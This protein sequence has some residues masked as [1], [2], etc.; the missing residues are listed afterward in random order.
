MQSLPVLPKSV[1]NVILLGGG[2]DTA[3]ML[4]TLAR[5]R[6]FPDAFVGLFV[7]YMQTA[8]HG[9]KHA[10]LAVVK[11]FGLNHCIGSVRVPM[12]DQVSAMVHGMNSGPDRFPLAHD[13]LPAEKGLNYYPARNLI[14]ASMAYSL[15]DVVGAEN[16]WTA[17]TG[18]TD[19]T[20]ADELYPDTGRRFVGAIQTAGNIATRR[21]IAVQAPLLGVSKREVVSMGQRLE[22]P[23][24]DT[25]SC[26]RGS[27]VDKPKNRPDYKGIVH[28]E[29]CISCITRK[30]AFINEKIPDPSYYDP[31]CFG[32]RLPTL[33]EMA[34]ELAAE[35]ATNAQQ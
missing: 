22:T 19:V 17:V 11:H 31:E 13:G 27:F 5:N 14:L 9:E 32:Y 21:R 3:V 25:C 18:S 2:L 35:R 16:I 7:D 26:L 28:C 10:V 15:A 29:L 8:F 20:A 24:G 34:A 6:H 30:M 23:M 4:S 12:V 33:T 1:R